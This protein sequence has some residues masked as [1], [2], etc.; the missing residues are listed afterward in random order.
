MSLDPE[1]SQTAYSSLNYNITAHSASFAC[2]AP[3]FPPFDSTPAYPL[4]LCHPLQE[5]L[6]DLKVYG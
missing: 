5:A 1:F 2:N 3:F 4:V 6:F